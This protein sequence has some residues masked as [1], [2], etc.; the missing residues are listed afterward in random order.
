MIYKYATFGELVV[1][2]TTM[3]VGIPMAM[4]LF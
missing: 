3:I 4:L 1:I 2:I